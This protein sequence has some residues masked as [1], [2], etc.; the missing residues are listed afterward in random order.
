MQPN[1][2]AE[3]FA[4]GLLLMAPPGAP[5]ADPIAA[6]PKRANVV[7]ILMDASALIVGGAWLRRRKRAV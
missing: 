3:S 4:A 2:W 1:R 5:V 6:A 7:L